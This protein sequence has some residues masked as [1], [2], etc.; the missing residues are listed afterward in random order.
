MGALDDKVGS[1][2][3]KEVERRIQSLRG[4]DGVDLQCVLMLFDGLPDP[5]PY[6]EIEKRLEYLPDLQDG[7]SAKAWGDVCLAM[8]PEEFAEPPQS[9]KC[10]QSTPGSFAKEWRLQERARTGRSLFHPR[11]TNG[12]RKAP[13]PIRLFD[14][15]PLSA[16]V[17]LFE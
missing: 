1:L 8:L 13:K 15:P 10:S 5:S 7:I 4:V 16:P 11:D 14:G 9:K 6:S 3:A 17:R 12:V 2:S